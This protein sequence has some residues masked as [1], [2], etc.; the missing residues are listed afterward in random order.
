MADEEPPQPEQENVKP[1][2]ITICVKDQ[3]TVTHFRIKKQSTLRKVFSAYKKR[4]GLQN[5]RF[6]FDGKRVK[7]DDTPDQHGLKEGDQIDVM[8][9]QISG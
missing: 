1:G 3:S 4:T 5:V 8:V 9:D 6:L 2:K 7:D